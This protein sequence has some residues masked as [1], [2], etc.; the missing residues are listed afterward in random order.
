MVLIDADLESVDK[1]LRQLDEQL[2]QS[3]RDRRTDDDRIA[4]LVPRR[5]IETWI[6]ALLGML[7][8]EEQDY[9]VQGGCD[10]VR[11]ASQTFFDRTRPKQPNLPL[12]S[13]RRAVPEIRRIENQRP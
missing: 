5:N 6:A 2:Q 4:I 8:D 7:V 3:A 12:D 11:E 13:L 10:R 9:K 1:R